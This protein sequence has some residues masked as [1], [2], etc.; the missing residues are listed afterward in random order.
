MR[1]FMEDISGLLFAAGGED[2][3]NLAE[4][5]ML[6]P[7]CIALS[8]PSLLSAV[9]KGIHYFRTLENLLGSK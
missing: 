4:W 1:V 7:A 5:A 8:L 6:V 9:C 3:L 2:E